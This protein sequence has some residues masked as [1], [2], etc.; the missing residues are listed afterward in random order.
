MQTGHTPYAE[1]VCPVPYNGLYPEPYDLGGSLYKALEAES[2]RER[3]TEEGPGS[4]DPT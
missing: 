2:Y 3:H 4:L 1:E